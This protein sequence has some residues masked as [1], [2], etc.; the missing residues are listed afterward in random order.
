MLDKVKKI[1]ELLPKEKLTFLKFIPDRIIFGKSYEKIKNKISYDTKDINKNIYETLNYVREHTLFGKDHIP[2]NFTI[3][4]SLKILETLPLISS[5]DLATNLSYYVSDEFNRLN[6]YYTT[7]GGT[8]RNPTTLLLSN[9]LYGTEWAYVQDIWSIANYNRKKNTKLTL[10]GKSLKNNKLVEYNP[11]YNELVVDTFKVKDSNAKKLIQ[12][13]SKYN[14][15]YLYGY[16][17]LIKE[18]I[19]YFD[20]HNY[21]LNLKGVLLASEGVSIKDKRFIRDYF[22]CKV[23]SFYGQSERALFAVDS[24]CS[25]SYKVATSYGY[26]RVIDGYLVVTSFVNRALPLINYKIGDGANISETDGAIYINNLTSRRGKDFVYLDKNKKI[27]IAAIN[28]HSMIQ[29]EILYYQIHQK[30]FRKIIFK[31]LKKPTSNMDNNKL[32]EIFK[33]EMQ[34]NLKDF[35]LEVVIVDKDKIEKSHRGKMILLIQDIEV[36]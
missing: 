22:N 13:V 5:Y 21:K 28:L 26:P 8:G 36:S 16:P 32:I 27:S 4:E 35:E 6:S 23:I 25:G 2:K 3:D 18:Y 29:R 33:K 34:E 31:I 30:E 20:K 17:S 12:E 15:Q 19:S 10:R 9:E 24:E 1:Y 14:I 11:I 7:T